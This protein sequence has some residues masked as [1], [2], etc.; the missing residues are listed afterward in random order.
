[1]AQIRLRLTYFWWPRILSVEWKLKWHE[2]RFVVVKW[3]YF[4]DM[5]VE[6]TDGLGADNTLWLA[7]VAGALVPRTH[8]FVV[9]RDWFCNLAQLGLGFKFFVALV[10]W[11]N[12]SRCGLANDFADLEHLQLGGVSP[13]S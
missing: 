6:D 4:F 8:F 9:G 12:V 10:A 7:R 2:F 3:C 1:M 5:E 13:D 11:R